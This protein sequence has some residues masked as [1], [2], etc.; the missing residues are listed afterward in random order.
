LQAYSA[1]PVQSINSPVT[2]K[3]PRA[4]NNGRRPALQMAQA[5]RS[6]AQPHL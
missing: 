5:R 2:A 6:S 4:R 1:Q 3:K